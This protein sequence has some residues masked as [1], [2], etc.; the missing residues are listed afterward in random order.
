MMYRIIV[1]LMIIASTDSGASSR[2]DD[3]WL[4][5][6]YKQLTDTDATENNIVNSSNSENL[7][8]LKERLNRWLDRARKTGKLGPDREKVITGKIALIEK[9]KE[10]AAGRE[11]SGG[12]ERAEVLGGFGSRRPSVAGESGESTE[13]KAQL[14]GLTS[15]LERL[16]EENGRLAVDAG[17]V[18]TAE[19]QVAGKVQRITELEQQVVETQQ[20]LQA[21]TAQVGK[22]TEQLGQKGLSDDAKGKLAEQVRAATTQINA[23]KDRLIQE[24]KTIQAELVALQTAQAD[25]SKANKDLAA[26]LAAQKALVETVNKDAMQAISEFEAEQKAAEGKQSEQVAAFQKELEDKNAELR[27]AQQEKDA[28]YREK[29]QAEAALSAEKEKIEQQAGALEAEKAKNTALEG[30]IKTLTAEVA[31]KGG[32]AAQVAQLSGE[33]ADLKKTISDRDAALRNQKA[34]FKKEQQVWQQQ[35]EDQGALLRTCQTD[36]EAARETAAKS[37]QL[38]TENTRL[39]E[40]TAAQKAQLATITREKDTA[41]KELAALKKNQQSAIDA[42]VRAEKST[43]DTL[44]AVDREA[45]ANQKAYLAQ[46]VQKING[47]KAQLAAG[48]ACQAYDKLFEQVEKEVEQLVGKV[49]SSYNPSALALDSMYGY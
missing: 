4:M 20:Q 24:N 19:E 5:K 34:D 40:E 6:E 41:M 39:Q 26:E 16:T 37:K 29:A 1:A 44:R 45:I 33:V 2:S 13:L 10:K 14:A 42:A 27:V 17:K 3:G 23:E 30:Q 11:A 25:A 12:R 15:Q 35:M 28:M 8:T 46:F 38:E 47:I 48:G 31:A 43:C 36:L 9:T 32:E 21:A 18:R 7:Y 22:L 49:T